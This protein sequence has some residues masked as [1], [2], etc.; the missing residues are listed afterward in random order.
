MRKVRDFE[1]IKHLLPLKLLG[2][3]LRGLNITNGPCKPKRGSCPFRYTPNQRLLT[4]GT[5][6][7]S[8]RDGPRARGSGIDP[9]LHRLTCYRARYTACCGSRRALSDETASHGTD[10]RPYGCPGPGRLITLPFD[11]SA[12]GHLFLKRISFH[13]MFKLTPR[14]IMRHVCVRHW[15]EWN[16]FLRHYSGSPRIAAAAFALISAGLI[17][18]CSLRIR[19]YH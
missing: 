10:G 12:A 9:L 1:L 18:G 11:R 3:Q 7:L 16:G 15:R 2:T 4:K 6:T 19:S 17:L 8:W 13:L 14:Q 5:S